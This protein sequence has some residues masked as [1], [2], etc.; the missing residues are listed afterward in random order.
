[1]RMARR[2]DLFDLSARLWLRAYPRRWRVTYGSDLL[3]T[4]A[5]LA[6]EG[7]RTVPVREGLAVLRAGWAL[8]WRE[9]PPFWPWLGY[10]LVN[11]RLPARYRLWVI[12][13]LLGP[14][15]E[16]RTM[17]ISM[18]LVVIAMAVPGLVV[19]GSMPLRAWGMLVLWMCVV[20]W[21]SAT[22]KHLPRHAWVKHVGGPVPIQLLP[23]RGAREAA[24]RAG[25]SG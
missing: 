7:A 25:S 1:M 22:V 16:A 24:R 20:T 17:G 13:D 10:R 5:D 14:L 8:R 2:P 19:E 12:D 15:Y 4:L 6:P 3:G 9:H 23:R 18:A 21:V 11:R